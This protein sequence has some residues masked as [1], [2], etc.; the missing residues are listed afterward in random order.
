MGLG[1]TSP[2]H[3]NTKTMPF[4]FSSLSA[5]LRQPEKNGKNLV[6]R[7][8]STDTVFCRSLVSEGYLTEQQMRHAAERYRLGRSK[9]GAVVF[10]E[11][12]ECQNIRDG[13]LMYY[14]D[15]CHRDKERNATWVTARLKQQ[16]ELSLMFEA[17]RCLFGLHLLPENQDQTIIVV[18][19]EKTA[20]ICSELYP[21]SVWMASGGLT[22]LNVSKLYPLRDYR[23]VLFPDTDE[24]GDTF[25]Q[26]K[27]IADAAQEFFRYPI[28]VS[29]ILEN[30]ATL[31]QKMA[32]IDIVDYLFKQK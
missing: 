26:W 21:E 5:L 18:E 16:R 27:E 31:E 14:Q 15:N 6:D 13:K 9:D 12:D 30:N 19:A 7:T 10:W 2:R 8:V 1:D 23:V 25:R 22:M 17:E 11:I 29:A 20:V 3:P 28:R 32:K 4:E 24:T